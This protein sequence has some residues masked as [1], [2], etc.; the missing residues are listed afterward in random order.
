MAIIAAYAGTGKSYLAKERKE[1]LDLC[2]MPYR[3]F[4]PES[5]GC[6]AEKTK[7]APYLV[8]DPFFMHTYDLAILEACREYK[9]VLIP[10]DLYTLFRLSH[11]YGID[12]IVCYPEKSAKKEY[13]RR[14]RA[15]GNTEEFKKFFIGQW[16]ERIESLASG[17][18]WKCCE[19][20]AGEYL[21]DVLERIEEIERQPNSSC[22]DKELISDD[23]IAFH[24][25]LL[26]EWK[27]DVK[28]YFVFLTV[29]LEER[30]C[31]V[32]LPYHLQ[33]TREY[34]YQIGKR[35]WQQGY[36]VMAFDSYDVEEEEGVV[37]DYKMKRE[38]PLT[39]CKS[40]E[41]FENYI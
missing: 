1:I 21:S 20:K 6:E 17:T 22:L 4:L 38:V 16:E 28:E 34:I 8:E 41:E 7:A 19:L 29:F 15:R 35:A 32:K 33:E 10:P 25:Q 23:I 37:T 30:A 13:Q 12:A 31:A 39:V 2:S 14:Y 24:K 27:E 36:R 11:N 26:R 3:Y 18:A 5:D 40:K 9:H